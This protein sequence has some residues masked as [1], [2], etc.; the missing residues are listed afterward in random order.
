MPKTVA[1]WPQAVSCLAKDPVLGA[2]ALEFANLG[3]AQADDLFSCYVRTVCG[4]QVANKSGEALYARVRA[5]CGN[6]S[7][8]R[9]AQR[10]RSLSEEQLRSLGLH[11]GKQNA[12]RA[13]TN[14]Y[15]S[16][17]LAPESVVSLNDAALTERFTALPGVGPWS[18]TMILLF[19]L[20]RP[21]VFAAGDF[22][23]RKA[24]QK[25]YGLPSTPSAKDS[26]AMGR[27]WHPWGSAATWLLWR[28]ISPNPVQY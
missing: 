12:L 23:V 1:W 14:G 11:R 20:G 25:L 27:S 7:G 15:V 26:L 19:G 8:Q 6:A 3:L 17:A 16:G 21:D 4:Q 9:F 22:G 28:S 13:L 24:L 2:L 10:L 18:A 5:A